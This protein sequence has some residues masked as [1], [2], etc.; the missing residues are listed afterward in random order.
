MTM[1]RKYNTNILINILQKAHGN[2]L[3]GVNRG[4]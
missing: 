4:K 1:L 2:V 3:F